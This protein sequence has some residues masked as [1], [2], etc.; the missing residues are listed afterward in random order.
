MRLAWATRIV[1]LLTG[2]LI[3]LLVVL[4]P[5][6]KSQGGAGE[7]VFARLLLWIPTLALGFLALRNVSGLS[8]KHGENRPLPFFARWLRPLA[9]TLLAWDVSS[10][11]LWYW[12]NAR[13]ASSPILI[14]FAFVL[15][16][17]GISPKGSPK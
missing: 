1:L 3:G 11:A 17:I 10:L 4:P 15:F 7:E 9:A 13:S 12:S 2:A 5:G 6:S 16:A 8:E 14:A